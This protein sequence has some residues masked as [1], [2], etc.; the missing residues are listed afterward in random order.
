[1]E[2]NFEH[3]D[4]SSLSSEALQRHAKIAARKEAVWRD[5]R[6]QTT[7]L[8][9]FKRLVR[10][11]MRVAAV[12]APIAIVV[13]ALLTNQDKTLLFTTDEEP[14]RIVLPDSSA[15]L[16]N[17]HSTLACTF[18]DARRDVRVEGMAHFSVTRNEQR[19]FVVTL[20]EAT[21]TVIGTQF[22]VEQ[23]AERQRVKVDVEEGCVAFEAGKE[24]CR[25]LS[26]DHAIWQNGRM[27]VVRH[28]EKSSWR[29]KS[30]TFHDASLPVIVDALLS[31][32]PELLGVSGAVE[33]ST[34][35]VTTE[36]SGQSLSEVIEELDMHFKENIALR[37]GLMTISQ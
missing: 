25:L 27:T 36:F 12:L 8:Q 19:P 11:S 2:L 1:M 35:L 4:P 14:M 23:I 24:S 20:G 29:D 16:L 10:A 17:R 30:L 18:T 31:Y 34:T 13:V 22:D 3:A 26:K 7:D 5:I 9:P 6:T 15:V 28:E 32:Y 37:D 21:V 33:D